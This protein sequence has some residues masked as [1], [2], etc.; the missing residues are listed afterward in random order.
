VSL[1]AL[2]T[3]RWINTKRDRM[4]YV[5]M[6]LVPTLF[7]LISLALS[8]ISADIDNPEPY[9][10]GTH[11]PFNPNLQTLKPYEG[12]GFRRTC[13]LGRR[14]EKEILK[15]LREEKRKR[16]YGANH[17][18]GQPIRK[19]ISTILH[20]GPYWGCGLV[21]SDRH[22]VD[23]EKATTLGWDGQLS[24]AELEVLQYYPFGDLSPSGRNSILSCSRNDAGI[25]H[26]WGFA[27]TSLIF[28]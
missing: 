17:G 10:M 11:K 3:K 21:G 13:I 16:S 24:G 12:R 23:V 22:Y 4:A 18:A 26:T 14:E 27:L 7:V 6:Y 8:K 2:L 19:W 20:F 28:L 15:V 25:Y 5:T 9:L 1:G